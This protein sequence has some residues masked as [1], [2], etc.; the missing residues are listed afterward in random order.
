MSSKV[1][2]AEHT[3][4]SQC[5]YVTATSYVSKSTSEDGGA[6]AWCEPADPPTD[7]AEAV[8]AST[9]TVRLQ[10][11]TTLRVAP[12]DRKCGG[13]DYEHFHDKLRLA[14]GCNAGRGMVV[15]LEGEPNTS[16]VFLRHVVGRRSDELSLALIAL[17]F[18]PSSYV[19]M[20]YV[21]ALAAMAREC[22]AVALSP[23][24]HY[25]MGKTYV[26]HFGAAGNLSTV[27]RRHV[28][29]TEA[30][31]VNI[32]SRVCTDNRYQ[33][34]WIVLQ[35]GKL[36]CGVGNSPGQRCI[37]TLDDTLY[38][39][40]R[41][42]VDAVRCVGVGNSALG[43]HSRDLRVRN[44]R[45][46]PIPSA[47]GGIEGIPIVEEKREGGFVN[48]LAAPSMGMGGASGAG[49]G[50]PGEAELL[51]EYEKECA[52]AKARAAKFGTEYKQPPPDAFF[53]WSEARRLRANPER[54]FATG[55]DVLSPEEQAKAQ[56]RKERFAEEDKKRRR[57]MGEDVED[58]DDAEGANPQDDEMDAAEEAKAEAEAAAAAAKGPLP[59]EQAWDNEDLVG[60]HRLDPPENLYASSEARE[61]ADEQNRDM[62]GDNEGDKAIV[63]PEKIHIFGIDWAAF[64][65]IRSDDIMAYFKMYG[66]SYI[67]WLGELSCNVL[68]EDK[69]SAA[70]ALAAL[71][72]ELP[73]PPPESLGAEAN[74][75]PPV[76]AAPPAA[77]VALDGSSSLEV[78]STPP[79]D[80]TSEDAAA[81][82][83]AMGD[84]EM[85]GGTAGE[86]SE[87]SDAAVACRSDL[88]R[89]GWRLCTFPIRKVVN[90]R[91]GRRGTRS[92]VLMRVAS[93][94]DVLVERP[95]EWPRPP[96]G[97]STKRILGPGD[98]FK[99]DNR[100]T[101]RKAKRRRRSGG[102]GGKRRNSGGGGRRHSDDNYMYDEEMDE[103]GEPRG[104]EG[105]L[106]AA[107]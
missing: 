77:G 54:G 10:E 87:A 20:L 41:S 92:R 53:K 16:C 69:F 48:V 56:R 11:G 46:M 21:C 75:P 104:L 30:V 62:E 63:V 83:A 18:S 79:P 85:G 25:A 90:D 102:G 4:A 70:R 94:F 49:T 26:V 74:P 68:F 67:E 103:G 60:E 24:S 50:M 38:N 89:M 107:R 27:I 6:A 33:S 91:F 84:G 43:R 81:V 17:A 82:D 13:W 51:A 106:R 96:P 66:P 36:S 98:D 76:A 29:E 34:Y 95:T 52:K 55:F 59:V 3:G 15:T 1:H 100:R 12:M 45:V 39:Q 22:I 58:G 37:G 72:S 7:A 57:E 86:V 42:G 80:A 64:K 31:D 14:D 9:P 47:F 73:S 99:T 23:T 32:P 61:D 93:S 65:Q 40:L 88:G 78:G 71:S 5:E 8:A 19:L 28:N 97:F 105:A 2:E 101:G 35:G 44:I